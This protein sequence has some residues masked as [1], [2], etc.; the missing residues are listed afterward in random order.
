M[1]HP[2]IGNKL[3]H[4]VELIS[5]S[6]DTFVLQSFFILTH[7]LSWKN[8]SWLQAIKMLQVNRQLFRFI[9][10]LPCF[11]CWSPPPCPASAKPCT[12]SITHAHLTSGIDHHQDTQH[13]WIILFRMTYS[14]GLF[15]KFKWCTFFWW[16]RNNP[17]I[18]GN[19]SS[20][21]GK[22][23]YSCQT[24]HSMHHP[25]LCNVQCPCRRPEYSRADKMRPS[26]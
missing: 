8:G 21:S 1:L 19:S 25:C 10:T 14:E 3:L 24:Q 4:E 22:A 6:S 12:S 16:T 23:S 20:F 2:Q 9:F 15:T 26:A 17:F 18:K 7:H 11:V 13:N 5:E